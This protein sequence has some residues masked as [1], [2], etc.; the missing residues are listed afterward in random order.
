M[1]ERILGAQLY[2]VRDYLKNDEQ[3]IETL[4]KIKNIG[5]KSAQLSC[6]PGLTP[7]GIA[8]AVKETGVKIDFTH[9]GGDQ[10]VADPMKVIAEHAVYGCSDIG[11]GGGPGNMADIADYTEFIA[12]MKKPLEVFKENGVHFLYHN[13]SKEFQRFDGKWGIEL[14]IEGLDPDVFGITFDVYWAAHAGVDPA[15]FIRKYG[16]SIR[17]LHLKDMCVINNESLMAEVCT[18]NLDFDDI[19]DA[20]EK[21][22]VKYYEVELDTPRIDP[23]ESLKISHDNVKARYDF[24]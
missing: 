8:A 10:I 23:F 4:T 12:K 19:L 2:T 15:K 16:S 11:L 24:K 3:F 5:Y 22:G 7:E 6:F 20:A 1:A 17:A 14:L 9:I 13:H 21:A 18:G